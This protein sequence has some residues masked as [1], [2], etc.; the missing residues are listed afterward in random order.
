MSG[1]PPIKKW[2]VGNVELA[3][4]DNEKKID[5]GTTVN[6]KTASLTRSYRKK[7][8]DQWRN[9]VI[10][11]IRRQDFAKLIALLQKAQDYLFFE[12]QKSREEE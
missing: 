4:W 5:G 3:I 12:T 6:F 9:E 2:R 10:N 7:D 1:K 8:E 11:N